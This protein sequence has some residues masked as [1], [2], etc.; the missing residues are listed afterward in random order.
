MYIIGKNQLPLIVGILIFDQVEVLDVA[1]PFEVFAVT[2][3][4]EERRQ[5]EPSPFRVLLVAEN[6]DQV[7]AIGGLRFTPDVTKDN[8][9]ELIGATVDKKAEGSAGQMTIILG[10]S[11]FFTGMLYGLF[12]NK[13]DKALRISAD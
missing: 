7:S 5:E 1:G 2:H 10:I 6:K 12:G 4:N 11:S 8:C 3:L 9:P 13:K